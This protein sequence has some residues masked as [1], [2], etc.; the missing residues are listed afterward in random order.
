MKR[1]INDNRHH[2]E[3]LIQPNGIYNDVIVMHSIVREDYEAKQYVQCYST[4]TYTGMY[5]VNSILRK[6]ISESHVEGTALITH[7][8]QGH[9]VRLKSL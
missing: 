3:R 7:S 6:R 5:V 1:I 9:P 2:W 4:S 8:E